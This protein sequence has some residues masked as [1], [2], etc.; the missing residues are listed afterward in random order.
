MATVFDEINIRGLRKTHL[1][2]LYSYLEWA[3]RDGTYYGNKEQFI[4]RHIK[5]KRWLKNAVDYANEE[6]VI[7]PKI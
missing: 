5:L 6:G 3:E 7:I 2:Q 1:E 4:K